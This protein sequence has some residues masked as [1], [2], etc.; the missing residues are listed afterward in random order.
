MLKPITVVKYW[1]LA[2]FLLAAVLQSAFALEEGQRF[3]DWTVGCEEVPE[4][5]TKRCFIFQT[6]VNNETNQPVLQMLVGY[7]PEDS[8]PAVI[9]TVPLGVA[10]PPGMGMKVDGGE[11]IRIPYDRCVPKGCIAGIPLDANLLGKFKRG[12][13]AQVVVPR[14]QAAR[15]FADIV[16]GIYRRLQRVALKPRQAGAVFTE[17]PSTQSSDILGRQWLSRTRWRGNRW[18]SV[19]GRSAGRTS[20]ASGTCWMTPS[21]CK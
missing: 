18:P 14:W 10:L 4:T 16:A 3:K 19:C 12:N 1:G 20:S 11:L 15:G 21:R 8:K 17:T 7:L 6:V 9:L 5:T 13:K 2:L